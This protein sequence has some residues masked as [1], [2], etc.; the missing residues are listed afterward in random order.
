MHDQKA[1]GKLALCPPYDST[2]WSQ[3]TAV[4][5]REPRK[6]DSQVH[7]GWLRMPRSQEPTTASARPTRLSIGN[8][9][10][11]P[12]RT[13][14]RL[15]AELSRLSPITNSRSGGTVTSGVL[16]SRPLS[17]SLK[18]A[19]AAPVRQGV[20]LAIGRFARAVVVLGFARP[21]GFQRRGMVV[22]EELALPHLDAIA[23]QAGDTLDP[24]LRAIA[25][26]AEHHDI[27]ELWRVGEHPPGLGQ[28]DLDRQR[29]GAV[30]IGIFRR[31]QC[32]ADQKR[33]LHRARRHIETLGG[34]VP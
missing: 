17:R 11:P 25:R 4:K 7:T 14:T 5:N 22:D 24:G 8:S 19:G 34:G 27:A 13:G 16:S 10:T 26:P 23:G 9:P 2:I 15:S 28:V 18:I 30:A 6:P 21:V 33:G 3:C 31:Q 1:V 20:D 12:S 32:I 29:G